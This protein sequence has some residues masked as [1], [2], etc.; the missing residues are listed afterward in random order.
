MRKIMGNIKHD[1]DHNQLIAPLVRG[2]EDSYVKLSKSRAI[3]FSE[4]VSDQSAA[5]LSA[6]L[7]YYDNQDHE[8]PIYLYLHSNGGAISGLNN[9]Y[10]VMQMVHAPI[11]TILLGKC[12]SAGAVIL[13]AGTKGERYALKSSNVMIH[14]VQFV[15]P[16]IGEDLINSKNYLEFVEDTND[17]LMKMLS[18]HTGQPLEK[19]KLDCSREMW[20]NAQT[21]L[22]YGIIDH[23]L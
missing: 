1:H 9:I 7:L 6:L 3:F 21:A 12:Y 19:L 5:E 16:I 13:A 15:F 8:E 18:K 23:I 11:K 14:G 2:Y 4:D 20:M 22:E 10:D 17:I